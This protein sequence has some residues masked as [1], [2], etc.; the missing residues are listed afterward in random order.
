M[1]ATEI[2]TKIIGQ[3]IGKNIHEPTGHKGNTFNTVHD[4]V[5]QKNKAGIKVKDVT[6]SVLVCSNNG[7]GWAAY[8][9]QAAKN[10][11]ITIFEIT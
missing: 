11:L 7:S 8:E 10:T 5:A 6:V 2:T 1:S 9:E 4:W 3:I